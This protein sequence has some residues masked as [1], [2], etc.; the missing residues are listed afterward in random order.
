MYLV[1]I[2]GGARRKN[3]LSMRFIIC[4]IEKFQKNFVNNCSNKT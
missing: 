1:Q 4:L 2:N 3:A